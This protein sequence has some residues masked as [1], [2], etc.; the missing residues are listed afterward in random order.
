MSDFGTSFVN[1]FTAVRQLKENE[2]RGDLLAATDKRAQE[3]WDL[4]SAEYKEM[5]QMWSDIA[6]KVKAG[7][8]WDVAPPPPQAGLVP[9][10]NMAAPPPAA[11]PPQA[12][13]PE[14]VPTAAPGPAAPR[15]AAMA[16][17]GLAPPPMPQGG[18][19][20]PPPGEAGPPGPMPGPVPPGP[21]PPGPVAA[22][23]APKPTMADA[24][25][26]SQKLMADI[27]PGLIRLVGRHSPEKA[28][29]MAQTLAQAPVQEKI[30]KMV[31]LG[32]ML[33]ANASDPSIPQLFDDVMAGAAVPGSYK[34]I[35]GREGMAQFTSIDAKTGEQ[36]ETAIY[37]AFVDGMLTM[38]LAPEKI[39]EYGLKQTE[40]KRRGVESGAQIKNWEDQRKL[41]EKRIDEMIRHNK[42]EEPVRAAMAASYAESAKTSREARTTAQETRASEMVAN[43]LFKMNGV[44]A[45]TLAADEASG[46]QMKTK[47]ADKIVGINNLAEANGIAKLT[48]ELVMKLDA[49]QDQINQGRNIVQRDGK[50]YYNTGDPKTTLLI[51]YLPPGVKPIATPGT[52]GMQK[53]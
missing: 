10:P 14:A 5:G 38:G 4:E 46:G 40:E 52:T 39:L 26:R 16:G 49:A 44:T 50:Y 29:Q 51:R 15:T 13:I 34:V 37:P 31:A 53:P 22:P 1:A 28:A 9:P 32:T 8:A 23:A 47:L 21:V 3:K 24:I 17:P 11:P 33:K 2:R 35:P 12:A 7:T 27:G 18:P 25:N 20:G 36:K 41:E 42:S 48:P 45:Q 30:T 19:A 6:A 43:T